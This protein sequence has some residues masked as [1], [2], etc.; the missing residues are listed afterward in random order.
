MLVTFHP[1]TL[2]DQA[3]EEQIGGLL[4][5]L[6]DKPDITLIFTLP[7]AD[8]GGLEIMR[9]IKDFVEKNDNAYIFESL[10]QLNYLSCMAIVDGIIGN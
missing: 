2:E 9:Q 10:G 1:A 7:N 8:T 4:A 5:A 3:P 6:S